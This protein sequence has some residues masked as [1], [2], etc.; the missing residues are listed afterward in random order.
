MINYCQQI[1]YS[2]HNL[3]LQ[4]LIFFVALGIQFTPKLFS[5]DLD[6]SE[7]YDRRDL[8]P[9]NGSSLRQRV[10]SALTLQSDVSE[11]A[12]FERPFGSTPTTR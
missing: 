9:A 7:W 11:L 2:I 4:K 12:L 1:H 3:E 10:Q 6:V 5:V 8:W